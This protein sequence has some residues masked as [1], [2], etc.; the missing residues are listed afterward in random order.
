MAPF[1]SRPEQKLLERGIDPARLPPGQYVTDKWPVLHAGRVPATAA[2]DYRFEVRGLVEQPTTWTLGEL[3][4]LPATEVTVDIHCVTRWSRFDM[5]WRGVSFR[6]LAD[7]VRP[8]PEARFAIARAA[9]GY[10]ANLPLESLYDDDVLIAWEADGAELTREHGY[11]VRLVVPKRYFWKSAKW[12][13][14]IELTADDRPGFW[15]GYGYH[16]EGDPFRE[17]RYGF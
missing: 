3:Q 1:R 9:Q 2:D 10:T 6:T 5:P 11:P 7:I 12:L 14:A 4:A 13:E 17:E 16:N 8:L 15:E